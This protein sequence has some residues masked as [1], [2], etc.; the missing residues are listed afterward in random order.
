MSPSM[1]VKNIYGWPCGA[2]QHKQSWLSTCSPKINFG[3]TAPKSTLIKFKLN[4]LLADLIWMWINGQSIC[5]FQLLLVL[6]LFTS[7]SRFSSTAI[8]VHW[9]WLQRERRYLRQGGYVF[10]TVCFSVC[11]QDYIKSSEQISKKSHG[12]VGHDPRKNLL[13]LGFVLNILQHGEIDW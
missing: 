3:F 10:I 11:Q 5:S 12:G 7:Y 4:Y 8:E 6:C 2:L 9:Y 13:Y 1:D